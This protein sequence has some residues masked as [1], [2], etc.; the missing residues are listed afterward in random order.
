MRCMTHVMRWWLKTT[1][2]S[3]TTLLVNLLD[4]VAVYVGGDV[5][6]RYGV[7]FACDAIVCALEMKHSRASPHRT[8]MSFALPI[9]EKWGLRHATATQTALD[10]RNWH[11]A[12]EW[13][14]VAS[15]AI[16]R[17]RVQRICRKHKR[18]RGGCND[19]QRPLPYLNSNIRGYYDN[20][21]CSHRD[22]VDSQNCYECRPISEWNSHLSTSY[23]GGHDVENDCTAHTFPA[24][25]RIVVIGLD[26]TTCNLIHKSRHLN[27]QF[28]HKER[29]RALAE[30]RNIVSTEYGPTALLSQRTARSVLACN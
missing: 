1:Q 21:R 20:S 2:T 28:T 29:S 27:C 8:L 6:T 23:C 17:W 22:C 3:T 25:E 7:A 14:G 13:L 30:L 26:T 15:R 5:S 4:I 11:V 16:H 10:R 19:I 9:W 18:I 12:A 24:R